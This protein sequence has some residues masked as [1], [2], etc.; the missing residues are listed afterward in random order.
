MLW[1]SN[2]GNMTFNDTIKELLETEDR[3]N[4]NYCKGCKL[5]KHI[6]IIKGEKN[7]INNQGFKRSFK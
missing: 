2:G 3:F 4:N 6:K 1:Q 7:G 5:A